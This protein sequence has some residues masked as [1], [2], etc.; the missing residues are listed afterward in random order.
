MK[1]SRTFIRWFFLLI[2]CLA[3]SGC[4]DRRELD[5]I[6]I[7]MGSG[8]DLTDDGQIELSLQIALPMGIQ[9]NMQMAG[10]KKPVMLV[11]S[12]GTVSQDQIGQIQQQLSRRIF[13]GHRAVF[14]I[15][16]NFARHG[17]DQTL[18]TMLR[19]PDSRYN[20]FILTSK[21]ATAKE[22]LNSPYPLEVIPS[23]G[24]K[25]MQVGKYTFAERIDK[26]LDSFAA[27]G[28]MP[29]T[30][31]IRLIK[32]G[33]ESS[34]VID[35]EAVYRENKLVGYLSGTH[36]KAF[37]LMRDQGSGMK[38]PVPIEPAGKLSTGMITAD[39]LTTR[40]EVRTF[41]SQGSPKIEVE[42]RAKGRIIANDTTL[43]LSKPANLS[44]AEQMLSNELQKMI[45]GL[46]EQ[47]QKEFQSDVL[48]FGDILH[49][50]HPYAWK[51]LQTEWLDTYPEVPVKVLASIILERI[52]RTQ[53]PGHLPK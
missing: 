10:K 1:R 13:F 37:K 27:K 9:G 49:I 3:L 38:I 30:G 50:Q 21:G 14:I 33:Q 47:T 24:M 31:A 6:A 32:N 20:C 29:A 11:S 17:V 34:F 28:F 51:K 42:F 52:G 39:L 2:P 43:D 5:E 15:G 40:R 22:V 12:K 16:E 53:K 44:R 4:W 7:V 26:F 36:S 46:I 8:V 35:G 25:N 23:I 48:G 45:S 19:F 41:V 18:D